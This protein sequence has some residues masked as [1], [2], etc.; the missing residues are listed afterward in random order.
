MKNILKI[1]A[2]VVAVLIV[3]LIAIPFLIDANTF[4]PKIESELTGALGR[5]VKVGNLSLSIFS[6]GV[7]ADNISIAD[8]PA[9]SKSPFVQAKSLKVGVEMIPLIFSKELRV[10]ELTLADPEI[11]LVKSENG[12]KWNFSS[13]GSKQAAAQN[14]TK[15]TTSSSNPE[16]SVAKLSVENGRVTISNANSKEKPHVYDKVNIE[17]IN[18]SFTS[19]FPFKVTSDLP[20]GGSLKLDGTAGP[21]DANNAAAT[22]FQA[23]VSVQQMNLASSGFIDPASGIAGIADFDGTVASDGHEAKTSGTLKA[24]KLQVAAKG[25][26]AGKL[27]ELQ[28]AVTYN[29]AKQ[30]GV[31][32][33]GNL[34]LGKAVAHLTGSYEARGATTSVDM[35]LNGQG[36]PVDDLEA[37]LPALGVVLPPGAT[38]KGGTLNTNFTIVGP[39]DKLV[40]TGTIQLE[41]SALAGFNLGSKLSAVSALSGKNTSGNDT[42]IQNFSSDVHVAPDG[43][44]ADNINLTV[45]SFGVLTGAGTVSPGNALDFKMDAKLEGAGIPFFIQGTTS[46]PKFVPDVKGMAS[47]MLK[48][49]LNGKGNNQNPLSGVTGLFKKK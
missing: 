14:P 41:N 20:A 22:P 23:K 27:V 42:T 26:P 7:T 30:A 3:I 1:L 29:L 25:S 24:S 8:D 37:M 34:S 48:G 40:T 44:R 32:S 4:R 36:M 6:G 18:F 49:V 2:I 19:S 28:Y 35:K 5:E 10:T 12:E 31:L 45:P 33:E 46:D 47:G 43:T 17:L 11:S 9:F 39:V 16:L 21:I 38:L 13:L 15:P